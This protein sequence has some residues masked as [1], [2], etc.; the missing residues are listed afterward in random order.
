MQVLLL[1]GIDHKYAAAF[2][3]R[4]SDVDPSVTVHFADALSFDYVNTSDLER[5]L[6]GLGDQFSGIILTSPRS[7]AAIAN[8]FAKCDDQ[9]RYD[10]L[11]QRL[12]SVQVFSVGAATSEPLRPF[13]IQCLGEQCGSADHLAA[14][15]HSPGILPVN[16]GSK[17]IVFLCGEKR[18]D[19]LPASFQERNLPLHELIVYSTSVVDHIILPSQLETT[20]PD[21][22]VFFSP[23]GIKAVTMLPWSWS[24]IRKAAIGKTTAS[25]L[26]EYADEVCDETWRA[27]AIAEKP[28]PEALVDAIFLKMRLH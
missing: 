19:V 3:K 16:C 11:L 6:D 23:S 27:D 17:P 8:I 10:N 22:I 15:L 9:Q 14:F 2:D 24:R 20:P 4:R 7:A 13:G 25:A 28:T 18:R 21:W 5:V 26:A 1:K 12:R